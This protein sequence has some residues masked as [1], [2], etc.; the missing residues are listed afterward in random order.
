MANWR[1]L[2]LF[3]VRAA[4]SRTF[5]TAGSK[6]PMRM[7][8]MAITTS[9]SISVKAGRWA[10]AWV[11]SN[12]PEQK[13]V[14]TSEQTGRLFG[15]AEGRDFVVAAIDARGQRRGAR[16]GVTVGEAVDDG[17]VVPFPRR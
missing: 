6:R 9:N 2:L 4:A 17:V 16:V 1:I 12:P 13:N 3:S 7:A 5:W 14:E 11:M 8:I 10:R 15:Q